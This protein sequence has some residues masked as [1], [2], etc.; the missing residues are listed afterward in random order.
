MSLLETTHQ[1]QSDLANYCRTGNSSLIPGANKANI[2][3]YKHICFYIVAE[4]LEATYP[5]TQTLLKGKEWST[6]IKEFIKNYPCSS[7]QVWYM[8][9]EF[10]QYLSSISHPILLKYPYLLELLWFEW[11]ELA[12]YMMEDTPATY[13]AVGNIETDE[14]ILNPEIHFQHFHYPVHLKKAK[15]IQEGDI[16]NYYLVI[17][18]KPD[19]SE[20]L[21]TDVSQAFKLMLEMLSKKPYTVCDLTKAICQNLGIMYS[22]QVLHTTTKFLHECLKSQLIIGFSKKS[23]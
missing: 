18:R 4:M 9:K 8:P 10:Y 12:L 21:F 1:Y 20:V 5:L 22:K 3:Q 15:T 2:K 6:L 11:L 19:T 23:V 14:L 7:P 17:H 13:I 16:G